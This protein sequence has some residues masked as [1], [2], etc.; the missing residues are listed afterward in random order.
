MHRIF[1]FAIITEN[2]RKKG[3]PIFDRFFNDDNPFWRGMGNVFDACVLNVLWLLCSLPVITI[4]PATTAFYYA[5]IQ[6][7]R[8]EGNGVTGD[9][10][11]SFRQNLKQGI[12]LGIPMTA[13]GAFLGLD[14][15]MSRQAGT[16]I[17][18]FFMVFFSV[19]FLIW[20]FIALYSFPLLAKFEKKNMEIVTWA[21]IL[22]IKNLGRTFVML[23]AAVF[24]LWVCHLLPGLV[25]IAFGL[26]GQFQAAL[27]ASVL[28][29]W[30]PA[31][32]VRDDG[33][34]PLFDDEDEEEENE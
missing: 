15:W 20:S 16:G 4:G 34:K 19:L 32:G 33:L 14:I 1:F 18:T 9:F 26:V 31:A 5:Q 27:I 28:K 29:P 8:D 3:I 24:G 7:V 25:F 13:V 17:Y 12:L 30:L 6:L 2:L 11:H 22:S 21:F 10:F 23:L